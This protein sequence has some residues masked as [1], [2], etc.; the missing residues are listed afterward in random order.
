[1]R[2]LA[3]ESCDRR[4]VRL[5]REAGHDV[6]E[7]ASR[8]PGAPDA[9]VMELAQREARLLLTEDKD[10]GQLVFA[11]GE[12]VPGVVLLRYPAAAW[13]EA[14]R[15]L[16]AVLRRR[17]EGLRGAFVTVRPGRVRLVRLPR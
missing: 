3:D 13:E 5:V 7:V 6:A 10:F 14:G 15:T 4:I 8:M 1:V 17:G 9:A 12:R 2:I 11:A 16:L